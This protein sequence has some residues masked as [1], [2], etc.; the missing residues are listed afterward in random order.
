MKKQT[1]FD[2]YDDDYTDHKRRKVNKKKI[3]KK[4]KKK[5]F[6]KMT[7]SEYR[8]ISQKRRKK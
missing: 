2:M 5:K 8:R 6:R 1:D 3:T 4:N 7:Q